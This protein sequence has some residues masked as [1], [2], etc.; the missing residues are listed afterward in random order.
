MVET[1]AH[2]GPDGTGVWTTGAVGLG[3]QMLWTTP[4]SK[5]EHQPLVSRTGALALTADARIDNRAELIRA[6]NLT[7]RPAAELTDADLILAAYEAWGERCPEHLLGDF[8][9]ALW[10]NNKQTLFCARD[11]FGVKPFYYF[12]SAGLFAFATELKALLS[13]PEVPRRLNEAKVVEHLTGLIVDNENTFYCDIRRLAPA[14]RLSV[15]RASLRSD[16]YW[17]LD[18]ERELRL[19]SDA[20]YVEGFRAHFTE[21]VRARLRSAYPVGSMLSGGL[22]SS[23]ITCLARDLLAREGRRLHTFSSVFENVAKCDERPFINAVLAQNG[24]CPHLLPGDESG[25][26]TNVAQILWHYEEASL[27]GNLHYTWRQYGGPVRDHG[28]RI[29]LDGFDGDTTVSHGVG[30]LIE[31]AR[32]RQLL[33]LIRETRSYAKHFDN[34][35]PWP[36][37]WWHIERYSLNPG[38]RRAIKP[39]QRTLRAVNRRAKRLLHPDPGTS[40]QSVFLRAEFVRRLGLTSAGTPPGKR[41]G[42][43]TRRERDVHYRRLTDPG[44]VCTLETLNKTAGAF[45]L[46][47][48]FPFW[49]VRLAEFCLSLPGEQK[50]H[51]GFG[52]VV[53]RR[54]MDEVLPPEV[55]WRGGKADMSHSFEYGLRTHN[56]VLLDE[57][58]RHGL[59]RIETYVDTAALQAAYQRFLARR[60]TGADVM[61]IWKSVSLALWLQQTEVTP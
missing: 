47:T 10:D 14:H 32:A 45:A 36:I 57:T 24:V 29:I 43:P 7:D 23:S 52:R 3:H 39:V 6:L 31:L 34:C 1:L 4:E 27:S 48:R 17:A 2:R 11:H 18:P 22:D 37:I 8:A 9:F 16:N 28:V 42:T 15:S 49:D 19:K 50:L 26:L 30:Y 13:L 25:P 51:G 60:A 40:Q 38:L 55:Q 44:M 59:A 12:A 33:T 61:G 41:P 54:A 58:M 35:P 21:A 56:S 46:E 53:M 5:L 20:E